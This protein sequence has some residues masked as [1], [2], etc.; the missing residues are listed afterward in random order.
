M[1]NKR[2]VLFLCGAVILTLMLASVGCDRQFRHAF[3]P[4]LFEGAGMLADD[5]LS[6]T[7]DALNVVVDGLLDGLQ[8]QALPEG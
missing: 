5:A 1:F 4:E 7:C 3:F 8:Q 6:G 2:L